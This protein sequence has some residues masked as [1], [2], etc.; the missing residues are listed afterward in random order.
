MMKVSSVLGKNA[1]SQLFSY[2]SNPSFA[3]ARARSKILTKKYL[4]KAG[5]PVPET[6]AKFKKPQDILHFCPEAEQGLGR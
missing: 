1:R 6:Y 2:E 5:I 3:R 4:A